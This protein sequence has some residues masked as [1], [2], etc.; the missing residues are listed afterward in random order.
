MN[1]TERV[2]RLGE[3]DGYS[4]AIYNGWVRD[5]RHISVR[6]STRL[7]IDIIR[8]AQ[9]GRVV[10]KPLPVL[11]TYCP[12]NRAG[13]DEG[14]KIRAFLSWEPMLPI[15]AHGY[16]VC[17]VD[18]RGCGASFGHMEGWFDPVQYSDCYD[19]TEWL[20]VQPWSD[21]KIGMYGR[22]YP[23]IIQYFCAAQKPPHLRAIFPEMVYFDHYSSFY[24]GG[25]LRHDLLRYWDT[26]TSNMYMRV[27]FKTPNGSPVARV[28]PVDEDKDGSLLSAAI[29]DH[30]LNRS[31]L[32]MLLP[33]PYRD[34]VETRSGRALHEERSPYNYLKQIEES[35]V[36]I[37]SLEGWYDNTPRDHVLLFNNLKNPQK[38]VIGPWYHIELWDMYGLNFIKE[39]LRWFDYWLKGID[40]GIMDEPPIH[41]WVLGAPKGK[42]WRAAYQWP[43]PNEHRTTFY[44]LG[45]PSGSVTSVNDGLLSPAKPMVADARDDYIVD[46]TT[47]TGKANRWTSSYA[48]GTRVN[49]IEEAGEDMGYPDLGPNDA[50]GLTFTT[51]PLEEDVEI[52]GHPV[53]HLWV[54]STARDGDF[55]AYLEEV[56]PNGFSQYVTEGN[57]RASHRATHRPPFSYPDIPWHRSCEKDIQPLPEEPVELAFDLLPTS[58]IFAAG[59]RIRLTIT[60]CDVDNL[61]TPITKP[62]PTI[63]LYRNSQ[64]ASHISLPVVSNDGA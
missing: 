49:A 41:Y 18:T 53:V 14:G 59:N 51:A 11:W 45:G 37:Y 9:D 47:T 10:E 38:M 6:D 22:S 7:A 23:G 54:R 13:I 19:I 29:R 39:L 58:N 2:S 48:G 28:A 52:T 43:L 32:E 31:I 50:K 36:A 3:Y 42:Q 25:V 64:R 24:P 30:K 56:H 35:G 61:M 21:G 57:L 26:N 33:L 12:Y 15:V 16:V 1:S 63:T 20:A 44:F 62:P 55:F 34:S 60:C 5:S 46:Y 4:G 27:E 17:A 8:P 40:N